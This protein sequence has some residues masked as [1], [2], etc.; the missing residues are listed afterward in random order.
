MGNFKAKNDVNVEYI[1]YSNGELI[2]P[3][4]NHVNSF[5]SAIKSAFISAG[6]SPEDAEEYFF[7]NYQ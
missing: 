1:K 5:S 4:E 2:Y 6:G 7:N 3:N